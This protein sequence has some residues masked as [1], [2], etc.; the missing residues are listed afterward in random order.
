M[1]ESQWV[2]ASG[3]SWL[4]NPVTLLPSETRFL[5]SRRHALPMAGAVRRVARLGVR[6]DGL[7]DLRAGPASRAA[8]FAASNRRRPVTTEAIGWYGGIILSIFLIGWAIGGVVFGVLAD[9]FG[10]TKTL[11]FTILIYAVFTGLAALSPTWW[12]LALLP[13]PHGARHR[14]RMGGGRGAGGGGLA[15]EQ[16]R[17][18]GGHSAIGV[19]GGI[20]DGGR[21]QSAPARLR[22]APHVRG[23]RRAGRGGAV[24]AAVGQG[25]G[26]MGQGARRGTTSRRRRVRRKLAEL[27]P[28]GAGALHAGRLRAGVCR[29]VRVV[30]RDE[31]DADAGPLF[32]GSAR[33]ERAA[34][35]PAASATRR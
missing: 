33:L 2:A 16:A 29:R 9:R 21:G 15:G 4:K 1:G 24:R 5:A 27:F 6:L 12:Q 28:A 31:L 8:R 7:H 30:G 20:S 23:R 32:A 10:R 25:T 18:G 13:V 22:L 26:A 3:F 34:N 14:R 35:S 19:G 11:V 17:Q